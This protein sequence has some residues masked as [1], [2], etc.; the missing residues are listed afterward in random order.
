VFTD[1]PGMGELVGWIESS[2][3]PYCWSMSIVATKGRI[4][5]ERFYNF[6]KKYYPSAKDEEIYQMIAYRFHDFGRRGGVSSQMTGIAHLMN[7]LGTDTMD[8]AYAATKYLNDGQKFGACSIV[9]AAHRTVTPW[10]KEKDSY[11]HAI[12]KYGDGLL[13]I[14]AD[15]YE[16]YE[17]VKYLCELAPKVKEMGGVLIVR[18]DSGNP[19]ECVVRGLEMLDKAFGSTMQESNLKVLNNAAII[20]GDGINDHDIFDRIL[21]SVVEAGFSPI[22]VAFGMG[23]HNHVA[24]R[25][26]L[27]EGYKTCSVG[28]KTRDV[29]PVMKGS[30][31]QFKTSLPCPVGMSI[32]PTD[33][34]DKESFKDRVYRVTEEDLVDGNCGD[35]HVLYDGRP[36]PIPTERELFSDTIK[37]T[38]ETWNEHY[39]VLP[40]N[41]NISQEIRDLQRNY[42]LTHTGV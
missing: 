6:F 28:T 21:P 12:N 38:F 17:G 4:R 5:K 22:N 15:S 9:A 41:E 3:L 20:Q 37:R 34:N 29:R 31:S 11:E 1:E 7:W 33:I 13:S 16:Y 27:E 42:L 25:S 8:S 18:P 39:P 26:D 40:N 30:N 35:L 2:L 19:I 32:R 23:Q 24:V 10:E 14:V 36:H